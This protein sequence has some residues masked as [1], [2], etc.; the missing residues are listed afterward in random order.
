MMG[1]LFILVWLLCIA[2]LYEI[3]HVSH[4]SIHLACTHKN[5]KNK[6]SLSVEIRRLSWNYRMGKAF[7]VMVGQLR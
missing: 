3:S 7:T 6:K 5:E 4:R 1:T 2:C